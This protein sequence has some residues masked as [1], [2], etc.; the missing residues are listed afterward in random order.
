M[1]V[2]YNLKD[3]TNLSRGNLK[4]MHLKMTPSKSFNLKIFMQLTFLVLESIVFILMLCFAL[5]L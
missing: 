4:D 2:S 3:I 5:C 1:G